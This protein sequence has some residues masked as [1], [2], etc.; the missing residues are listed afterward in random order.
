MVAAELGQPDQDIVEAVGFFLVCR[1]FTTKGLNPTIAGEIEAYR[2][3]FWYKHYVIF[4][5]VCRYK[6]GY[7]LN[8]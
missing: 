5:V 2:F 8:S 3:I 4:C 7:K 1:R 6:K